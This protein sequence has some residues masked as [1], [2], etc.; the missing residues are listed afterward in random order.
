MNLRLAFTNYYAAGFN[1]YSPVIGTDFCLEDMGTLQNDVL[2]R[3]SV[4]NDPFPPP[5]F[6][7]TT[8]R[9]F[10][11]S[12]VDILSSYPMETILINDSMLL[13]L[14]EEDTK[15]LNVTCIVSNR[16]GSDRATTIIRVCGMLILSSHSLHA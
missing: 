12:S 1:R 16:F 3:C 8:A 9:V 2:I 4:A 6:S 11:N 15:F 5:Q 13:M 14:F 10:L 7:V